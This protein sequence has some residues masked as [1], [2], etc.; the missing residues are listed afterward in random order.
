MTIT[1]MEDPFH[2]LQEECYICFE[3]CKTKSPCKCERFVHKKCLEEWTAKSNSDS[4]TE[5]LEKYHQNY[6]RY[7]RLYIVALIILLYII[8]GILG[9]ICYYLFQNRRIQMSYPWSIE[10]FLSSL[11]IGGFFV[12]LYGMVKRYRAIGGQ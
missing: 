4:C 6:K 9:Q 1:A 12:F 5:C 10:Y 7:N 2:E 3:S 8:F 11:M